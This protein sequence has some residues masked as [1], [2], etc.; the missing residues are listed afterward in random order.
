MPE[1]RW[2]LAL[3]GVAVVVFVYLYSR[4]RSSGDRADAVARLEPGFSGDPE[5]PAAGTAG[6]EPGPLDPPADEDTLPSIRFAED[7]QPD[8]VEGL[9]ARR[10]DA[11][12]SRRRWTRY[13]CN[14]RRPAPGVPRMDSISRRST[15][16]R[17]P[18][19]RRGRS[20]REKS[21]WW[22]SA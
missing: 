17:R 9:T 5:P 3:A 16:P 14:L 8:P 22:R 4:R 2:I 20:P 15:A 19:W 10:D 6:R 18:G 13:R 12:A 21:G 11:G 1:L 7:D